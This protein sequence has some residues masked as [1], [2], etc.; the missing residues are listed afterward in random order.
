MTRRQANADNYY[1]D[2]VRWAYENHITAGVGGGKFGTGSACTREQ[3]V[4]FL[5]AFSRN[6][7]SQEAANQP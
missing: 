2:A 5:Y 4:S 3:M 6:V 1:Y 7:A